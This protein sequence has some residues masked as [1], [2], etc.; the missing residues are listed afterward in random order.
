MKKAALGRM[1]KTFYDIR[2]GY[3]VTARIENRHGKQSTGKIYKR[4]ARGW[5]ML[6]GNTGGG[7][8]THQNFIRVEKAEQ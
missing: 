2:E 5:F 4:D 7:L 1:E 6:I 8:V 3:T